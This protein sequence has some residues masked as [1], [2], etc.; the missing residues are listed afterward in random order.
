VAIANKY[1]R[2]QIR[3]QTNKI[4]NKGDRKQRRS[5]TKAIANKGDRKQRRSPAAVQ[6]DLPRLVRFFYLFE[7]KFKY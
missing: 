7:K 3:S 2:K 5:Q 1:D 6:S 4:A